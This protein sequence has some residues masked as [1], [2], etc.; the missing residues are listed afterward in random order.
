MAVEE[1]RIKVAILTGPSS[2]GKSTLTQS[3]SLPVLTGDRGLV[4][5]FR[6]LGHP[7][8]INYILFRSKWAFLRPKI[9]EEYTQYHLEWFLSN[10]RPKSF[11][12]EAWIYCRQDWRDLMRR[13]IS[14]SGLDVEFK[15]FVLTPTYDVYRERRNKRLEMLNMPE[16]ESQTRS[17]YETF[18]HELQLGEMAYEQGG[19]EEISLSINEWTGQVVGPESLP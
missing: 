10:G 1:G 16:D 5:G 2:A 4:Q 7:E 8:F 17:I 19:D 12:A 9:D 15:L 18:L 14:A 6:N 13:A 11:V 3:L